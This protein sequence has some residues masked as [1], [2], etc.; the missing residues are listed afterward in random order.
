MKFFK[1]D[2]VTPDE[3][4][5]IFLSIEDISENLKIRRRF[6]LKSVGKSEETFELSKEE[7]VSSFYYGEEYGVT[8]VNNFSIEDLKK[9]TK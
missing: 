1:T 3:D 4:V 8:P 6:G 9:F 7:E 5:L 2:V